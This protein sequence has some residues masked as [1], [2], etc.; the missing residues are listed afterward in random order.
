M[1]MNK[2]YNRAMRIAVLV[3]LSVLLIAMTSCSKSE[4]FMSENT[5]K[6]MVVEAK[7]AAVL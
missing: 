4:F 1:K 2:T 6:L 7:N 3:M 5:G